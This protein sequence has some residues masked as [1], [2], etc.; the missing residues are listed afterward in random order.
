MPAH[1][2]LLENIQDGDYFAAAD[3]GDHD[4]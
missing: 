3:T 4:D 2:T 1:P